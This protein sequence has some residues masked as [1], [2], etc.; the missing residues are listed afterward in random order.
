MART[1]KRDTEQEIQPQLTRC[2]VRTVWE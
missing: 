1:A 2:T